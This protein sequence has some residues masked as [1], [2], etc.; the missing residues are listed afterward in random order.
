MPLSPGVTS[1]D[2][3]SHSYRPGDTFYQ[4]QAF[5]APFP[6]CHS[7]QWEEQERIL[8]GYPQPTPEHLQRAVF[9]VCCW[10][11]APCKSHPQK[12]VCSFQREFKITLVTLRVTS[13]RCLQALF[14]PRQV[15]LTHSHQSQSGDWQRDASSWLPA[16]HGAKLG[17]IHLS[18]AGWQDVR[19]K[20]KRWRLGCCKGKGKGTQEPKYFT[21][22]LC[23]LK[24]NFKAQL[25]F[26]P[27]GPRT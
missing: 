9:C 26:R 14:C 4:E 24:G 17:I 7:V 22:P 3:L 1:N 12:R 2:S 20:S 10:K 16:E 25:Y 8:A 19:V 21:V 5:K 13:E 11:G 18:P 15:L 27:R 23:L 6:E